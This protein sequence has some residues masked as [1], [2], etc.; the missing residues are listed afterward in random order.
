MIDATV[1]LFGGFTFRLV[2][3]VIESSLYL[4]IGFLTAGFLRAM[5]AS[6]QVRGFFGDG[7]W[8]GPLRSW[9][10]AAM[11]LPVC[12]LGVLPV[13]RELRRSGV[14]PAAILTFALAA[15]ML[16][17]VSLMY[18]VSYLGPMIL[19]VM[20]AGTMLVSV[21]VGVLWSYLQPRANE[22]AGPPPQADEAGGTVVGPRRLLAVVVHAAREATGPILRDVGVGLVGAAAM[23]AV[24]DPA[25]LAEHTFAGDPL[26]IPRVTAVAPASYLTPDKGVAILPEMLKFRQSAGAALA[27]LALGVGMT[28]GHLSWTAR[29]FGVRSAA[30]LLALSLGVTLGV[31]FG[32]EALVA[33]VGTVNSDNDHF[34]EISNP[35]SGASSLAHVVNRYLEHVSPTQWATLLALLALVGVGIACRTI[36]ERATAEHL[37]TPTESDRAKAGR[38]AS[39]LH[40]TVPRWL[41]S[42]V[43]AVSIVAVATAGVYAYY[44]D[45]NEIF[46][47]MA[48][49]KADFYGELGAANASA[50]IHHLDIWDRQ[51]AK[52]TT[53]ALIRLTNPGEDGPRRVAELR[54]GIR[55][56]R[57]A[58]EAGRR[59]EARTIFIDVSKSYQECRR[60]YLGS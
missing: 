23:A 15:P 60:A 30:I 38:P 19:G 21:G 17:P 4:L 51:A 22:V 24:L 8:T 53:G 9:T 48:I 28:L 42:G 31:S 55:A 13:I 44:P 57:Q 14:R 54:S 27:L 58:V 37:L 1:S 36:G 33:P 20:V 43:A 16:N 25:F 2:Q 7:R 39:V 12:S 26:A 49:I 56:L 46:R 32:V 5:L 18:G 40:L 11:L 35:I 45:P 3:I 34:T 50:P 59:D 29:Q 47:D 41:V 52:L 10:V 6:A